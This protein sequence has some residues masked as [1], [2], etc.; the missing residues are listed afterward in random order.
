MKIRKARKEDWEEYYKLKLEE[1]KEYKKINI[2]KI[3]MPPKKDL[4]KEFEE[5]VSSSK[6]ITFLVEADNKTVA[7]INCKIHR[8]FWTKRGYIDD[9]FV[10]KEFRKKGY[11]TRLM[12]EFSDFLR[13]KR[14]KEIELSVNP[15]NLCAIHLYKELGFGKIKYVMEK[16]LK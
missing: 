1:S 12:N 6:L 3:R 15:K 8:S 9:I 10:K 13:K 2:D 7:Y 4:K 5:F 11:G 14:I 16:K